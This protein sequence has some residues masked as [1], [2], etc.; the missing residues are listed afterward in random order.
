MT[1]VKGDLSRVN[2]DSS[3]ASDTKSGGRVGEAEMAD[4]EGKPNTKGTRDKV[5]LIPS[6][7]ERNKSSPAVEVG[8]GHT[9]VDVRT[10]YQHSVPTESGYG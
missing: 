9:S 3:F 5:N 10:R 6:C 8:N 4:G 2:P 7:A 1:L